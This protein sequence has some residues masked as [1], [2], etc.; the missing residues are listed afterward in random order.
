M[1][2]GI[3]ADAMLEWP[4]ILDHVGLGLH[5]SRPFGAVLQSSRTLGILP[6]YRYRLYYLEEKWEVLGINWKLSKQ[7]SKPE[8]VG[9]WREY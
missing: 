5:F 8:L 7:R 4:T 3:D 9:L 1:T 6:A 2:A